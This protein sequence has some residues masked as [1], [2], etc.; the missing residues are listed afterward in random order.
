MPTER[1]RFDLGPV[2]DQPTT[3]ADVRAFALTLHRRWK[4]YAMGGTFAA[5]YL[6]MIARHGASIQA[7]LAGRHL[8]WAAVAFGCGVVYFAVDAIMRGY[9][10]GASKV[11]SAAPGP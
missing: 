10:R 9:A 11:K 8:G 1:R 5:V 3:V 2:Q 6:G 7:V 4:P